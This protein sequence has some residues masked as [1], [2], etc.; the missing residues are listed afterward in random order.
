MALIDS[1]NLPA[2]QSV[3]LT[4]RR[5]T[6]V[7]ESPFTLSQQVYEHQG[8]RW[9]MNVTY[10]PQT[11]SEVAQLQAFLAACRGRKNTFTMIVDPL[12]TNSLSGSGDTTLGVA[13]TARDESITIANAGYLDVGDLIQIGNYAYRVVGETSSTVFDI[14][15]PLREDASSGAAV[16]VTSPKSTFRL[17]SD[18]FSIS[19]DVSSM[20]RT[21]IAC[22][23]AL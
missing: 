19:T 1:S 10:A 12:A 18:E 20:Y 11:R 5:V 17:A 6:G 21:T 7:S 3:E 4:L 14:E 8:A 22:V 2:P 16:D 23:E 9:E 13:G 15:P